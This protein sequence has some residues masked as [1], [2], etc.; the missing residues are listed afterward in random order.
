MPNPPKK[1]DASI[2]RNN[3]MA[4]VEKRTQE[5]LVAN[6]KLQREISEHKKT[7][8]ALRTSEEYY[9]AIFQNTGTAMVIMEEDTTIALVNRESVKFVGYTPEELEG[10][11]KAID[12]V[13]P[14]DFQKVSDYNQMR[15]ADATKP[16]RGYEFTI[17]DRYGVPKDIYM[18]IELMP[19]QRKIIASFLDISEPKRIESALKESEEK[20]RNIFEHAIEGI[21]QTS[22]DGKVLSANPAFAR[23]LGYRSPAETMNSIKD[24]YYEVFADPHRGIELRELLREHG[25]VQDFEIECRRPDGTRKW[26]RTNVR[27]VRD[28]D[29]HNLFYEGT[30]VDIT[31]RKRMQEDIESK[32][33]SLEETNAALRVLLKHREQDNAELEEKVLRNIRELVLPYVEKLRATHSKDAVI[34]NI[35]ES[36]LHD[37]LTPFV[38]D[39]ASK[40]INFTPKEI[41]VADLI[42]KGKT[43]KDISRILNLS[44]STIDIHRTN[45]RRKLGIT[46]TK[47]NLQSYLL[48]FTK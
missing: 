1:K 19:E 34:V 41:Q 38:R 12:F 27:A 5:L 17:I 42:K 23:I 4:L 33:R 31:E 45:V 30:I 20:Y 8:E 32:S 29:G 14:F 15:L 37:I 28:G 26:I 48:S 39:L 7:E 24:I 16:P 21:F 3:L 40:Y 46:N 9:R 44:T 25:V 35:I 11:K 47:A 13:A 2:D 10:T 43:T 18:T 36:N 22:L 6:E